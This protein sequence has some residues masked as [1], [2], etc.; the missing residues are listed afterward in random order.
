MIAVLAKITASRVKAA[1]DLEH[2]LAKAAALSR[3]VGGEFTK[4]D[5]KHLKQTATRLSRGS[6]DSTPSDVVEKFIQ[7]YLAE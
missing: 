5:L 4:S 1:A 2:S 7:E 3:A 6:I